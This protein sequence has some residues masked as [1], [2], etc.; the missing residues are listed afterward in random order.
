MIIKIDYSTFSPKC[1]KEHKDACN[2]RNHLETSDWKFED[3]HLVLEEKYF[4]PMNKAMPST[5]RKL[6]CFEEVNK[7]LEY[8][9]KQ[10][11]LNEMEEVTSKKSKEIIQHEEFKSDL[12]IGESS[13]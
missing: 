1:C 5:Q 13:R 7:I 6:K 10:A 2:K 11:L 12:S 4:D 9:T 8:E 3:D